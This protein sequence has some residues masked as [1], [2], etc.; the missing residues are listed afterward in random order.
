MN[1]NF[2]LYNVNSLAP[3]DCTLPRNVLRDDVNF[4]ETLT[5]YWMHPDW[6]TRRVPGLV[7]PVG[8]VLVFPLNAQPRPLLDRPYAPILERTWIKPKTVCLRICAWVPLTR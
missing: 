8:V 7:T 1:F 4:L 2:H 3:I 6:L 5:T